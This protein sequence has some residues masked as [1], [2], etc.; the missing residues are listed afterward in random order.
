MVYLYGLKHTQ[1]YSTTNSCPTTRTMQLFKFGN[2]QVI[3]SNPQRWNP[4][5]GNAPSAFCE[6]GVQQDFWHNLLS[7]GW[8]WLTSFIGQHLFT[9]GLT[10]VCVV[11]RDFLSLKGSPRANSI[12]HYF[13]NYHLKGTTKVYKGIHAGLKLEWTF[14]DKYC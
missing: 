2:G 10:C 8:M 7:C 5:Y 13:S 3:S 11:H 4:Q 14:Y 1:L 12:F 9:F 6:L